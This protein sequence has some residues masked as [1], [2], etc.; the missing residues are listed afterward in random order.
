LEQDNIFEVP[1]G[2]ILDIS[3]VRELYDVLKQSIE[4]TLPVEI[5]A[6][7]IERVDA[8]ALQLLCSFVREAKKRGKEVRWIQPSQALTASARLLQLEEILDL[9]QTGKQTSG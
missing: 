2:E 4:S 8:A 9:P 1:C 5:D 3:G 7:S 6:S